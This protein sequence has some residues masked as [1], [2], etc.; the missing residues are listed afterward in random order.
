MRG[1]A[2]P[3]A[4]RVCCT[5]DVFRGALFVIIHSHMPGG[6]G[7]LEVEQQPGSMEGGKARQVSWRDTGCQDAKLRTTVL[8]NLASI[9]EK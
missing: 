7:A 2:A 8:I 5:S 9:L 3:A 4:A 6:N 1:C